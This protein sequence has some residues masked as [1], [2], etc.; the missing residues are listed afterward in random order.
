MQWLFWDVSCT[1][2]FTYYCNYLKCSSDE[3]WIV[4]NTYLQPSYHYRGRNSSSERLHVWKINRDHFS[5][6]DYWVESFSKPHRLGWSL[7]PS[8][9][10]RWSTTACHSS[11]KGPNTLSW[12]PQ[13]LTSPPPHTHIKIKINRKH[14][15]WQ[16]KSIHLSFQNSTTQF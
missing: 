11:C 6:R 15:D 10:V 8:T 3:G 13:D 14:I 9:Q 5:Q 4:C 1:Y 7:V 16:G 2:I 12:N